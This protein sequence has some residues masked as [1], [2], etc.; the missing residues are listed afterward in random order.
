MTYCETCKRQVD[1]RWKF[2]RERCPICGNGLDQNPIKIPY[3]EP[4]D[5]LENN[6]RAIEDMVKDGTLSKEDIR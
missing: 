6:R 1:A 5:R 4:F 2:S 3:Y